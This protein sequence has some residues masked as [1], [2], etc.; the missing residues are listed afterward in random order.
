VAPER[1]GH[2][3]QLMR[4]R[5][6]AVL[7]ALPVGET[8]DWV[9]RVSIELTTQFLATL[10]DFPWEDR[11]LLPYWSD[12]TTASEQ[13]G[14]TTVDPAERER[15]MMECHDYFARLWRE[16]AAQPPAF[17]FLS[18]LA[19]NEGTRDMIDNPLEFLGNIMLL[20]V[21]GNDTT[22][23]SMTGGVL[24]FD[25]NPGELAKLK[26]NPGLVA[27][28]V[29][30][31]IRYQSPVAHMRRTALRDVEIGGKQIKKGERVV[32]WYVS[33]NRDD[34]VIERPDEFLIDRQRPRHHVAFGFGIHRCMGNRAAELQLKVLWEEILKRFSRIEVIG[35]PERAISNFILGYT[36]LTVKLHA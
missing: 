26:A 30:E 8:F 27:G 17:D 23:N 34:D 32:M 4:E 24:F 6:A 14:N 12:V 22:R 2:I 3:E 19:H 33:G 31:I 25:Q 5:T 29:S 15:I 10:F 20:V 36:R 28:A 11:R 13:T 16:R 7:D 35:E 21:G 9:D 18:L 1:L